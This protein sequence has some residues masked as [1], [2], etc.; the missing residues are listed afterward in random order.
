M[1]ESGLGTRVVNF[2]VDT[3]VVFVISY[4]LYKW[5][6]FYVMYWDYRPY[7]FY[8]FFYATLFIYY[9]VFE[10]ITSRTPGKWMTM[11]RVR[12]AGGKRPAW[13]RI[14][15]RTLLRFTIID[16]FFIPFLNR[17]LHDAL[18]KTRVVEV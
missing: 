7:Q 15:L 12:T 6:S 11:T 9:F 3:V 5:Y 10:S 2:V 17:S 1:N 18:S 8:L 13:Y 16:P 4:A 14:L